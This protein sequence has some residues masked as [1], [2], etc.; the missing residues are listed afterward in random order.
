MLRSSGADSAGSTG[1]IAIYDGRYVV[2]QLLT[3][4]IVLVPIYLLWRMWVIPCAF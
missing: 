4:L 2:G 1:V 3:L